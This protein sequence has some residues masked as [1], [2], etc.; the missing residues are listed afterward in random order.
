MV[1]ERLK[2]LAQQMA[3]T[4]PTAHPFDPLSPL[5]IEATTTIIA[6]EHQGL[7][8]NAVTL[9]EPRKADMLAWLADPEHTHRPHR[10]A[11]V[12]AIGKGSKV[13]DGLVDLEEKKIIKWE[14]LDGVQ[15]LVSNRASAIQSDS[16]IDRLDNYGG[17]ANCRA[18]GSSRSQGY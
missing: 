10:V 15:P 12:V 1:L 2:Q 5:E 18:R 16:L 14:L 11:D 4:N 6:Q 3:G 13:Y 7:F 9:H 17:P 8:Y